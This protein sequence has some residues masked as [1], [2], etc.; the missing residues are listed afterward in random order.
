[1]GDAA[2][3]PEH[4]D[5]LIVGAGMSGINA[6]YNLTSQR[7]GTSFVVLEGKSGFGGTWR[8]HRY[9]G[10]RA[11][12][13]FYT[14]AFSFKPWRGAP[15]AGGD[16]IMT[17]LG[18]VIAENGLA[19]HIRYDHKILTADWS[20]ALNRWT[21]TAQNCATG[22][23][24]VFT[25]GFLWMCQGYFRH[26]AGYTPEWPAV[27]DFAGRI[28]HPQTWPD[29]LDCSGKRVLVIGSGATAATLVPALA[30]NCAHVTLLQ[31]SPTYYYTGRNVDELVAM[32]QALEI[33][34]AWIYEIARRKLAYEGAQFY[35]RC[36]ADPEGV[37][38]DL[39]DLARSYLGADFDI[40]RH[41][42]PKYLPW[43]QRLATIPDGD[44]FKAIAGGLASVV[45]DTIERFTH[46]GVRVASGQEIFADIIVTATG[47]DFCILGDIAFTIDE[48]PLAFSDTVTYRGMMFTGVPNMVW[49]LGYF[50]AAWTLRCDLVGD[51]VCR[52]LQH[53][54]EAGAG[55]VTVAL[56]PEDADMKLLPFVDPENFNPGY[57][58][59]SLHLLP[60]RGAKPKWQ[61]SQDYWADKDDFPAIDLRDAVF[62]YA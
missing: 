51:F 42:R 57:L 39:I 33:D 8:G 40:E 17:Y 50:R 19:Q 49:V 32:L 4:F 37:S 55:K 21:V 23:P 12:T 29:E 34:E 25:A 53:M 13:N 6:A 61:H 36:F 1:M 16:Q 59:R 41:F 10:V 31:R 30:G 26:D 46:G 60:R 28:V 14:Y 54:Q 3:T 20:S 44:L 5:V 22:Q 7:P 47:F 24:S 9:P 48:M 52:L 18:E 27:A 62:V 35:R 11:D 43:R 2:A 56:R 45:T 38:R 15:Y 58:M